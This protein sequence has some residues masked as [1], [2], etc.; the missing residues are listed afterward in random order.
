M[1]IPKNIQNI[2]NKLD[3]AG[4]EAYVV[5]GCVRD[6]LRG[7]KPRDWD[8]TTNAKPEEIQQVF[9]KS[10]YNNRFG[11]VVVRSLD[12]E[13]EVTPYR[14]EA[15]YTD[16]R[17]PD[18]VKF[19]VSLEEDLARRDF[20][21]NAIAAGQGSS[22]LK[23]QSL[24]LRLIDLFDG[25]KDLDK[26]IIRTVGK[27]EE[28]FSEDALR[29]LRAVRF[30]AELGFEIEKK[31]LAAIKKKADLLKFVSRERIRDELI[32]IIMSDESFKGFWLMKE[33]GLL[34]FVLPELET[35]IGVDQ[36][37]HHPYTVFFHNVLSLQYCP[38]ENYLVRL[39]A[40]LHD[41]AKPQTKKGEGIEATFHFHEQEGARVAGRIM[42]RLKFSNKEIAKVQHLIRCHMFFYSM[43]EITDAGVRRLIKRIGPDHWE[44]LLALRIGDRMGSG[45][46]VEKPYKLKELERHMAYVKRDPIDVT[47]LAISG[48]DVMEILK[49]KPS[50]TIGV[51]LEVLL[52]EVLDDPKKN[53][54]DYL[55][56]RVRELAK[57]LDNL[58]KKLKEI[59]KR[60]EQRG[61]DMR[62]RGEGLVT[63]EDV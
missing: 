1:N 48:H 22:K 23:A 36:N 24:R 13:V 53:K 47:K 49:I 29:L 28:R 52:D 57:D 62:R 10:L 8:I 16:K 21:I 19:G 30:S 35:G 60:N 9:P 40:L 42:R 59:K 61:E 14:S 26:K 7:V 20:T 32:K 2:L 44:D 45:C 3:Q 58:E 56:A 63:A 39:A 37:K 38:S 27:P 15:K 25:Q 18:K 6:A 43:G 54:K 46:Q 4:Y 50:K 12:E 51:V 11:T 34:K 5:G 41:V 31:T 17:H 55:T 33:T